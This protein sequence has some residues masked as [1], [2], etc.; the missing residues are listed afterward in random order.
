MIADS[1]CVL[2]GHEMLIENIFTAPFFIF[3]E[4]KFNVEQSNRLFERSNVLNPE[5]LDVS[6][7][8]I[9]LDQRAV[10]PLPDLHGEFP[11]VGFC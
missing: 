1:L 3:C 5:F 9:P 2:G 7:L 6:E 10:Y 4:A 11:F 8:C